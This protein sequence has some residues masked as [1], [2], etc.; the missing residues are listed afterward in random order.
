[1]PS[2][3][4][5]ADVAG[6]ALHG[7]RNSRFAPAIIF[8]AIAIVYLLTATYNSGSGDV[9]ASNL[10][11]WQI[12][13][14]DSTNLDEI[15]FPA[16]EDH[17]GRDIWITT[18]DR[19]DEVIARSPGPVAAAVPAY[20]LSTSST[21]SVAPGAATAA[22]LSALS[23]TLFFL[24]LRTHTRSRNAA[25][26]ALIVAFSTPVWSVSANGMWPHTLTVLGIAGMAWGASQNR[27]WVVGVFGGI[28][29]WGRLHAALIVAVVGLFVTWRRKSPSLTISVALPSAALLVLQCL[30][31]RYYYGS[32]NPVSA[33]NTDPIS[34]FAG[35]HGFDLV[36]H[37]GM[38]ISPDRGFLVW[39]PIFLLMLPALSRAWRQLPDWSR[40]LLWGGLAYTVLQAFLNRFSGG[41]AFYGYRLTLEFLASATPALALAAPAMGRFARALFGP[42]LALQATIIFIGAIHSGY[43]SRAEDVWERHSLITPL[44]QQQPAALFTIILVA[45]ASGVIGARIWAN[46]SVKSPRP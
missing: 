4:A 29:L 23:V 39:T 30:W 40:A 5:V 26:A 14:Q 37:L 19:G 34:D 44:A 3:R 17:P 8:S 1:V 25:L 11:S 38:W 43:G 33:Y 27:W 15:N 22:V 46:P 32:W 28:V 36:N 9:V 7:R 16:L 12:A 13:T 35:D 45:V 18:N 21:F 31:T 24:T 41:D 2:D 6:D 42:V 20:L 10:A